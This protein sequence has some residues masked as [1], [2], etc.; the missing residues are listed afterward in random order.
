MRNELAHLVDLREPLTVSRY[1]AERRWTNPDPLWP[2]ALTYSV[3]YALGE[4]PTA[5][6]ADR[7]RASRTA[8][9][10]SG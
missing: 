6:V 5:A 10:R 2:V 7:A 9:R 3:A 8:L 1:T 4:S